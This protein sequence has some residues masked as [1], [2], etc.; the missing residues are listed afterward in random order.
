MARLLAPLGFAA[1]LIG[2]VL[3]ASCAG[4]GSTAPSSPTA[5]VG[6]A[7]PTPTP[8]A[9]PV[10]TATDEPA[11]A[12]WRQA[13]AQA[14]LKGVTFED[15]TW[16]GTRFVAVGYLED[17]TGVFLDSTDGVTWHRQPNQGA[18]PVR[19]AAGPAG[20]VVV[21]RIGTRWATW[22]SPDGLAW[23]ARRDAFPM[24]SL[25]SDT[26]DVTDVVARGD[27]WLAV[28]RRDP[29]CFVDCGNAPKRAYVWTSSD[30]LQWTRLP[31]QA[32]LKGGAIAAVARRADGFVAAGSAAG[33]AAIWTSPD[34]LAWS[35]V[36]DA[37][38]FQGPRAGDAW[39]GLPPEEAAQLLPVAAT[40]VVVRDGAIVVVG[41]AYAQDVCAPKVAEASSCPG[42]RAWWSADGRTWSKAS[43]EMPRNGQANGLAATPDG[44]LMVGWS[45][46]CAGGTWTS[47]DGRAWRC[48]AS[49]PP[50]DNSSCAV[51]ASA[52]VEIIMGETEAGEDDGGVIWASHVWYRTRP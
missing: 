28:G 3:I 22:A 21:G 42:I 2:A 37:P 30:G 47:T 18:Y 16:T 36:P 19:I 51:G 24:P 31:D 27:G 10:P 17:G 39:P 7:T 43:M 5:T 44:V 20:V 29:A 49:G 52:T 8:G 9:T 32:A 33:H 40:N 13:P 35:R 46:S 12:S 1:T 25:G 45:D 6:A 38:M 11:P 50:S 15:V 26:V 23:T 4:P 34:G 14:A 41:T 48:E